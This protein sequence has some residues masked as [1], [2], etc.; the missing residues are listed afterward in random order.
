MLLSL[1]YIQLVSKQSFLFALEMIKL[2]LSNLTRNAI[3][4][5]YELLLS[6]LLLLF[7]D[8]YNFIHN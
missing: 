6:Q 3:S 8:M 4:I 1:L 5:C 2:V 7:K